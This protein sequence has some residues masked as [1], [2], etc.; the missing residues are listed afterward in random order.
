[1][2]KYDIITI[3]GATQDI[4]YYTSDAEIINNKKNILK[5]KLIAFEYGAK[6]LSNDITITFG[7]GGMNTA[8][9]CSILGL[10]TSTFLNLGTDWIGELILKELKNKKVDTKYITQDKKYYS[11]FSFIINYKHDNEHTIFG[12]R[13]SN[14]EL[15]ISKEK[16]AKI[17]AKWFYIASLSGKENIIKQNIDNIFKK[18]TAKN[19]KIAWNPGEKQIK[20]GNKFFKKYLKNINFF[21]INKDEAIELVSSSGIKTNNIENIIRIIHSWGAEIVSITDGINGA[22]IFDGKKLYYKKATIQKCMN[23]TGAGDAYGSSFV[24]G[25]ILYKNDLE[26]SLKLA[27]QQSGNVVSKIGAQRGLMKRNEIEKLLKFKK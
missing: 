20:Y 16:L 17:N 22:Y 18:A 8:I 21:N 4:M 6:I 15:I 12:H 27:I 9:N 3:G 2:K 24:S 5:Q 25:M 13:G 26:K 1:M 23:T 19:I 11:G 7:G 14:N 10:K